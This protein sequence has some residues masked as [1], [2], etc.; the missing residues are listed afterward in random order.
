M[1]RKQINKEELKVKV[2]VRIN[3][4]LFDIMN[5]LYLWF[6]ALVAMYVFI[7]ICLVPGILDTGSGLRVGS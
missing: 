6:L 7:Q 1:G 4:K 2:S 3:S 5:E